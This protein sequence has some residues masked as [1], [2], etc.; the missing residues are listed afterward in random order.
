MSKKS[1]SLYYIVEYISFGMK[2]PICSL[3]EGYT[4]TMLTKPIDFA[5]YIPEYLVPLV[6]ALTRDG[7]KKEDIPARLYENILQMRKKSLDK[8]D[9]SFEKMDIGIQNGPVVIV[10]D[11]LEKSKHI[12][13]NRT[14]MIKVEKDV[15]K[16]IF[17]TLG[18]LAE[19]WAEG[20]RLVPTSIYGIRR[21][22]N[23]STLLAHTD[24]ASSHVI[25]VIM[26]IA[27]DVEED[28]PLN[29][30]D[31]Q[32]KEHTLFLAA[33]EMLWYE[34]ARLVH[35]RQRPFKGS[36]FDNMFIHYMPKGLWYEED[37]VLGGT[38]MKISEEAVRWSQRNMKQ[39]NW[40]R[41]WDT[42]DLYETNKKVRGLGLDSKQ[43]KLGPEEREETEEFQHIH[44][45]N[46]IY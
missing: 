2:L 25:S 32:G 4:A 34:S 9:I 22:R 23:R 29:I 16:D 17:E 18:P 19:E 13:V 42:F 30:K 35:G 44:S 33:G 14:Q 8:G 1:V 3:S 5:N 27:Q 45:I 40:S 10:N 36:Y 26:N 20:L 6:P 15:R 43:V 21:Y 38:A 7:F 46:Q 41:A 28:W 39:T 11:A 31:N 12:V 37:Q 24:K